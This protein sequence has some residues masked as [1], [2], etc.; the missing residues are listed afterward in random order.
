MA[1]RLNIVYLNS[2]D[3]GRY[4]QPYG[5]AVPTP[6]LQRFAEQGVLFRRA[7]CNAP[8]CSPSRAA[9]LTGMHAHQCGMLG[10]AHRGFQLKNP[11]HHL[12]RHLHA[13]GYRTAQC[14]INHVGD[15]GYDDQLPNGD[16]RE[17]T[18]NVCRWLRDLAPDAGP[19]YLEV[20]FNETHRTAGKQLQ[21]HNG[22]ESPAGDPRYV[23]VPDPLPDTPQTRADFADYV[24][25][26]ERLDGFYGDIL[27]ALD[28]AGHAD[29]T[30]VII[31]TDHGIAFP[32]MKSSLT[33][34]GTGVLMMLRGPDAATCGG[35]VVDALVQ[36]LDVF[37]T[38]CAAA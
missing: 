15:I 4:I 22:P 5:H 6:N 38:V 19:F 20:G 28:D 13:H 8:T 36:H 30:L 27:S 7:F 12:A 3:T 14:G 10:L 11:D 9:L 23:R 35:K 24:V 1:R 32:G 31:T 21:W 16:G 18:D 29:D 34:H 33:D 37:P 2:H 26:A 17:R 25:A